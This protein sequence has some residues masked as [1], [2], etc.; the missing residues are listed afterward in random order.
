[1]NDT[2]SVLDLGCYAPDRPVLVTATVPA[3]PSR[4]PVTQMAAPGPVGP[5]HAPSPMMAHQ[6]V[7]MEARRA[8]GAS[9]LGDQRP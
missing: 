3:A 6:R 4:E 5:Q 7:R 1:M 8:G 2:V 9:E